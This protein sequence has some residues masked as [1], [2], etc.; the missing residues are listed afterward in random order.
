MKAFAKAEGILVG[1]T[2]G[3]ALF[4]AVE[5]ARRTENEGKTIVALMPDTG[6]HYLSLPLFE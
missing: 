1:I 5:L 6:E 3:A 4:A 2:S